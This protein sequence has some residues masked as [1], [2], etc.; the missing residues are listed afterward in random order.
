MNLMQVEPPSTMVTTDPSVT[1]V[2]PQGTSHV[3]ANAENHGYN[4]RG[5]CSGRGGG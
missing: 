2:F 5:G 3:T 4:T 1:E